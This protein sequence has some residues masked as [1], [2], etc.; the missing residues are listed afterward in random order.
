M[1]IV[2]LFVFCFST[3]YSVHFTYVSY[4]GESTDD[5]LIHVMVYILPN[6]LLYVL[7]V[8]V[9]TGVIGVSWD[10]ESIH[11]LLIPNVCKVSIELNCDV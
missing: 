7:Y 3:Y 9:S 8:L 6:F 10:L 4:V 5:V 2:A 1:Y 11:M